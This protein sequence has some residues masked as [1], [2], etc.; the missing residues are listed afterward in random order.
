MMI[1][2]S[3]RQ[4][5]GVASTGSAGDVCTCASAL[6]F[7]LYIRCLFV[8]VCVCVCVHSTADT[9]HAHQR[10]RSCCTF[11]VC[12]CVFV[13]LC[14][15]STA[16]AADLSRSRRPGQMSCSL[17]RGVCSAT[18]FY[19]LRNPINGDVL[20][21][22]LPAFIASDCSLH[23][24]TMAAVA[25][26]RQ[27]IAHSEGASQTKHSH[28]AARSI[29]TGVEAHCVSPEVFT[30]TSAYV[31]APAS[32]IAERT[33]ERPESRPTSRAVQESLLTRCRRRV[34]T[35]VAVPQSFARFVA[36]ACCRRRLRNRG[37]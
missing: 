27:V 10:C 30:C 35:Q 28:G 8:C 25:P 12:S 16:D 13:C 14:V 15:H 7:V 6:P 11:V 36:A 37:C 17:R 29:H 5:S 23:P 32:P 9:A 34:Q 24:H 18:M 19:L 26:T 33:C 21:A 3:P 1:A 22:L 4:R 31:R 2:P 20:R